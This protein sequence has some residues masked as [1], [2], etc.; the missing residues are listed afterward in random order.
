MVLEDH[1][2]GETDDRSVDDPTDLA[3]AEMRFQ[4]GPHGHGAFPHDP[5]AGLIRG[6]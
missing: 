2:E 6:R 3:G 4:G 1:E 5:T